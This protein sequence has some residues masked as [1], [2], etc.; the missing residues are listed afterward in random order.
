[1]QFSLWWVDFV[2]TSGVHTL[3]KWLLKEDLQFHGSIPNKSWQGCVTVYLMLVSW[4]YHLASQL[5]WKL[6][7]WSAGCVMKSEMNLNN[8][9]IDAV[10]IY[11][12]RVQIRISWC[13]IHIFIRHDLFAG[14]KVQVLIN[15]RKKNVP[16]VWNA[17]CLTPWCHIWEIIC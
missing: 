6:S 2:F 10:V 16:G 5:K 11:S 17:D 8:A 9:M 1:M 12:G 13:Y 15:S 4:K 14:I 3:W 7:L